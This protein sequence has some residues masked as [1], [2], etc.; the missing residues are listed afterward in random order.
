MMKNLT[1]P[2]EMFEFLDET[3]KEIQ[4]QLAQL[5]D[6]VLLVTQGRR[7]ELDTQRLKAICD[8]FDCAVRQ[9]HLDEE[10]HV[11]PALIASSDDTLIAMTRQLYQDHGWLESNWVELAPMLK[12]LVHNNIWFNEAELQHSFDVFSNLNIEHLQLEESIAYPKAKACVWTW[13]SPGIGREMHLRR[14]LRNNTT[15]PA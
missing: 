12:G 15:Q 7:Q 4:T 3:H 8:F 9:H 11:F 10:R 6:M 1:P 13:D 5:K 2:L 14:T